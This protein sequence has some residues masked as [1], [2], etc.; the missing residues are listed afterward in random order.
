MYTLLQVK[1]RWWSFY[2]PI[3]YESIEAIM[4]IT[5]KYQASSVQMGRW[6]VSTRGS[7]GPKT[8]PS[9][10]NCQWLYLDFYFLE[11]TEPYR[12]SRGIITI[13]LSQKV[14]WQEPLPRTNLKCNWS[15]ISKMMQVIFNI[16]IQR[17]T[18]MHILEVSSISRSSWR[19][20]L[21]LH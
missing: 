1:C 7:K 19:T 11:I 21:F 9:R 18:Q 20:Y 5:S 15:S 17:S 4:I 14:K 2:I 10:T 13:N 8:Y 6:I 3:F 16:A 12:F